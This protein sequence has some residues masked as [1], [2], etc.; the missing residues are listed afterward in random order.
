MVPGSRAGYA[1][2]HHGTPIAYLALLMIEEQ[3]KGQGR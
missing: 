3:I 2:K 1:C